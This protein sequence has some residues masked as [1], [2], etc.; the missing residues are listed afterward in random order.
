MSESDIKKKAET[1][2]A[3]LS[4]AICKAQQT[5]KRQDEIINRFSSEGADVFK[6]NWARTHCPDCGAELAVIPCDKHEGKDAAA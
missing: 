6:E 4:A 2:I 3:E 5:I 1:K